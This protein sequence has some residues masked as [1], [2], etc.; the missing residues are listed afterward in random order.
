VC[1]R[2]LTVTVMLSP[3][4]TVY[5]DSDPELVAHL[6]V[7]VTEDVE[8]DAVPAAPALHVSRPRNLL[9]R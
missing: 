2:S 5:F 6:V 3:F 9:S 7:R 4:C 8:A 1:W